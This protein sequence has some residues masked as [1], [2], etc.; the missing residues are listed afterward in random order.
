MAKWQ[1]IVAGVM[2]LAAVPA[3]AKD[4]VSFSAGPLGLRPDEKLNHANICPYSMEEK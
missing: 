3:V 4:A 1:C 2:L